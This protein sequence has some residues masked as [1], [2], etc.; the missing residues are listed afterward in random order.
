MRTMQTAI[1]E[2]AQGIYCQYLQAICARQHTMYLTFFRN[3][4]FAH[5]SLFHCKTD[6][7][8]NRQMELNIQRDF[9]FLPNACIQNCT[10]MNHFAL[11]D[12]LANVSTEDAFL[13]SVFIF[14]RFSFSEWFE[15]SQCSIIFSRKIYIVRCIMYCTYFINWFKLKWITHILGISVVSF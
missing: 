8:S 15:I 7:H 1:Q 4:F 14:R 5:I 12:F 3:V 2:T 9:V 10:Q 13:S 6:T 11:V